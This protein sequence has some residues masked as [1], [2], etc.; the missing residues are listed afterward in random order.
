V[1]LAVL[2]KRLDSMIL[3][4][5]SNLD[6]A[7]IPPK[8]DRWTETLPQSLM[9]DEADT[10]IS[11]DFCILSSCCLWKLQICVFYPVARDATIVVHEQNQLALTFYHMALGVRILPVSISVYHRT[12]LLAGWRRHKHS[13]LG[14]WSFQGKGKWLSEL[15][16]LNALPVTPD[17][18]N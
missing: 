17:S 18:K 2:G 12:W 10:C 11:P 7:I 3:E 4:V 9:S 13:V 1:D 8:T 14:K 5:F 15:S 16:I 6:N